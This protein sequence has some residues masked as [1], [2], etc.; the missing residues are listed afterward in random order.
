[1]SM[2]AGRPLVERIV[3]GIVA[4]LCA[5]VLAIGVV[6]VFLDVVFRYFLSNPLQWGDEVAI[7]VLIAITFLGA[8]LALYRSEH[9]GVQAFRNRAAAR[10]R[11]DESLCPV[12]NLAKPYASCCSGIAQVGTEQPSMARQSSFS[13]APVTSASVSRTRCCTGWSGFQ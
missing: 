1:M 7:A 3:A 13:T 4:S 12:A 11:S 5:V 9:L 10:A 8:A 2:P 6:V